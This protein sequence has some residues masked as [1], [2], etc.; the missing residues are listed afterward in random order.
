MRALERDSVAELDLENPLRRQEKCPPLQPAGSIGDM[1]RDEGVAQMINLRYLLRRQVRSIRQRQRRP[2]YLTETDF[3]PFPEF[4]PI[5]N[6]SILSRRLQS[7]RMR[8]AAGWKRRV[9]ELPEEKVRRR[10]R[11]STSDCGSSLPL[12]KLCDFTSSS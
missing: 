12:G 10:S 4:C 3:Q 7:A 2:A 6:L 1:I 11:D 9:C 5:S 8:E